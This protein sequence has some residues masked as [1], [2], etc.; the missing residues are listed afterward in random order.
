MPFG[1]ISTLYPSL[2]Y[3]T[4]F[5]AGARDSTFI[6]KYW[7]VG[8]ADGGSKQASVCPGGLGGSH[9]LREVVIIRHGE[10]CRGNMEYRCAGVTLPSAT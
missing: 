7:E 5:D 10:G 2:H 3:T 4:I 9:G 1:P 6:I 8:S